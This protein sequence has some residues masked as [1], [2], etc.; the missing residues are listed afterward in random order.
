LRSAPGRDL[1]NFRRR[2]WLAALILLLLTPAAGPARS[3][4]AATSAGPASGAGAKAGSATSSG[5]EAGAATSSGTEMSP[6]LA[7]VG[8]RIYPAPDAAP[9]LDGTLVVVGGKILSVGPRAGAAIPAGAK[10]LDCAGLA[11]AAGFQ[12]SHVHFEGKRWND[13]AHAPAAQLNAGLQ[14]MLTRYG[15]VTV[16]DAAS[17]LQN[18]TDLRR[19]IE[20]GEVPGPRILTAGEGLYP[21]HGVPFYL[22]GALPEEVLQHLPQPGTPRAAVEIVQAHVRGGADIIK[23]FTGSWVAHG[24]VLPMP[25]EIAAAAVA[26]AHR[27]GKLVFSHPSNLAGLEVALDAKVD[28]LAHAVEDT[29]GLTP[30]HLQRMRRQGMTMIPTLKLFVRDRYLYEILDEVRDYAHAGGQILFGTD[31]G[32]LEDFD[33]TAEYALMGAAGLSWREILASLTTSPAERFGD[34]ARR[35]RIAPGMDADLVVLGTDPVTDVRG[36]ADVRH[37]IRAGAVIYSAPPSPP[38]APAARRGGNQPSTGRVALGT[39]SRRARPTSPA[40]AR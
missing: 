25:E 4:S 16:V 22:H 21:P 6:A 14:A 32:F 28:V 2:R 23:L 17:G 18:T 26:E 36:F 8:A 5:T 3:A 29:R 11:I 7:L 39:A 13:A 40:R 35:G 31:V 38:T 37:A 33:P 19:R 10:T 20:S 15:F 30:A 27:H 34:A 24:K 9:I 1:R 12:N